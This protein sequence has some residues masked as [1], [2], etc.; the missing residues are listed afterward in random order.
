MNENATRKAHGPIE[1]FM[2]AAFL[3]LLAIGASWLFLQRRWWFPVLSS[4]HGSDLDRLF[5]VTLVVTGVLFLLLQ[6]ILAF[7]SLRYGERQG[8]RA[9]AGVNRSFEKRFAWVAALIVFGVD[10]SV[11]AL[12]EAAYLKA[13][14]GAPA[15][16][17]QIEVTVEQFVWQVRYSGNDGQFGASG[18]RSGFRA[19][20]MG[21]GG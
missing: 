1:G 12:G 20:D 6:L 4:E 14:G 18:S 17:L 21:R 7:C 10:V 8:E 9:R 11:S 5:M 19:D 16:S 13:F 3:V 2:L 15:G